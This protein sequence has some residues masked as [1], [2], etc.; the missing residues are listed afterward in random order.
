MTPSGIAFYVLRRTL[1]A[2]T[3]RQ[4][5]LLSLV[6]SIAV[7]FVPRPAY[8]NLPANAAGEVTE[9]SVKAA[10]LYRFIGYVEW[11]PAVFRTP[12][13]PYVIAV[14]GADDIAEKLRLMLVGRTAGHRGVEVR[15]LGIN[16]ALDQVHVLY[17]G[18][19]APTQMEMILKRAQQYPI[20]SVTDFREA[21]H[22]P[23]AIQFKMIDNRIRFDVALDTAERSNLKISSRML[24]VAHKV[25][26]GS[27]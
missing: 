19:I 25:K 13:S 17:V 11:P 18:N 10:F 2:A 6:L 26:R 12:D 3:W 1:A 4:L 7:T 15:Q 24:A 27:S 5:V 20:L 21:Q 9:S 23:S 8:G 14:I 22:Q 16:D